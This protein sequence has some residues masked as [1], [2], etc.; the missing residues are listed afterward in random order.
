MNKLK[1][2][3]YFLRRRYATDRMREKYPLYPLSDKYV[4]DM[5]GWKNAI[6]YT[7]EFYFDDEDVFREV[8]ATL[9]KR[10]PFNLKSKIHFGTTDKDMIIFISSK[11]ALKFLI[12]KYKLLVQ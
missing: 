8:V 11:K 12:K 7:I 6:D 2:R 4:R 1:D 9:K 10:F 3:F 5:H